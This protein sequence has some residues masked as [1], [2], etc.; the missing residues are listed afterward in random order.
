MK[1]PEAHRNSF[2]AMGFYKEHT[3]LVVSPYS[4]PPGNLRTMWLSKYA[5]VRYDEGGG[6]PQL[7]LALTNA[8]QLSLQME[9]AN[10]LDQAP[11]L[12]YQYDARKISDDAQ[13]LDH[14]YSLVAPADLV[15]YEE[16]EKRGLGQIPPGIQR[17]F[18]LEGEEAL[19]AED[20]HLMNILRE[21]EVDAGKD[22]SQR[23]RGYQNF[24][25]AYQLLKL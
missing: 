19:T 25:E 24:A 13:N 11:Y 4:V 12:V 21:K 3:V 9:R 7:P 18:L 5:E 23:C 14:C 2:G 20:K 1:L 10:Q 8:W 16:G 22:P 6:R 15:P 17:R